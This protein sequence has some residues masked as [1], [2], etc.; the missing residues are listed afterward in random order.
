MPNDVQTTI[1]VGNNVV[2]LPGFGKPAILGTTAPFPVAILGQGSS[3]LVVKGARGAENKTVTVVSGSS[4][5]GAVTNDNL[6][7][8]VAATSTVAAV[9]AAVSV[10]GFTLEALGDGS[11]VL[12]TV[13]S[14]ALEEFSSVEVE[15][16]AQLKYFYDSGDTEYEMI[17]NMFAQSPRVESIYVIP[18]AGQSTISEITTIIEAADDGEWYALLTTDTS[19]GVYQQAIRDYVANRTKIGFLTFSS[20]SLLTTL[21]GTRTALFPHTTPSDHV[22]GAWVSQNLPKDPG[23]IT[24]NFKGSFVNQSASTFTETELIQIRNA[25]AQAYVNVGGVLFVNEGL[26]SDDTLV[27]IDQVRSR[28][29]LSS[30]INSSILTLMA[31]E[32]KIPYDDNGI[33]QMESVVAEQLEVAG[34]R[35]IIA[36][37]GADLEAAER[38]QSKVYQYSVVALT[39]AEIVTQFPSNIANRLLAISFSYVEAGSI[40]KV[41]INGLVVLEL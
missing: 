8:T 20:L 11:G 16:I 31:N 3:G 32:D 34:L 15:D 2:S 38:S 14:T 37:I 35:S 29:W 5:A 39:R 21:A 19:G 33:N 40:H 6:Q 12:A 18:A 28:D 9:V 30:R 26:V 17:L 27:Y 24:W 7:I 10:T 22:E 23:S 1:A 41:R 13:G 25:K 36:V 4:I